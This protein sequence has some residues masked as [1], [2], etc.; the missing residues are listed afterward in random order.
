MSEIY[1]SVSAIYKTPPGIKELEDAYRTVLKD[2]TRKPQ[3]LTYDDRPTPEELEET[4]RLLAEVGGVEGIF[5]R[6]VEAKSMGVNK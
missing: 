3:M 4:E 5:S 6:L 1:K 2:S